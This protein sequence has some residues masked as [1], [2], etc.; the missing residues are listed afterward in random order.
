MRAKSPPS[1]SRSQS[2]CAPELLDELARVYADLALERLLEEVEQR[3]AIE[4][5]EPKTDEGET[6]GKE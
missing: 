6:Y 1:K 2:G 4:P 5:D 3:P